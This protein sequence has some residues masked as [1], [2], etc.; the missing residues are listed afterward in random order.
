ML[1]FTHGVLAQN[2]S[3][4]EWVDL[5]LSVNWA[6]CNVGAS[7]PEHFGNYYAWGET[8]PKNTYDWASYKL[9]YSGDSSNNIRFT[10]YNNSEWSG[11]IDNKTVLEPEDD[12][13]NANWGGKWRMPTRSEMEELRTKCRWTFTSINGVNGYR[14]TGPNGNSIFLPASGR[15]DG[16]EL[17]K[18]GTY[19]YYWTSTAVDATSVRDVHFNTEK[20]YEDYNYCDRYKG[21]S[22]RPVY[23]NP[24]APRQ[25]NGNN[26]GSYQGGGVNIPNNTYNNNNYN[27]SQ[28]IYVVCPACNGTGRDQ[29]RIQYNTNG[30]NRY[31]PTCG[32]TGLA[33]EHI[34]GRCGRCDGTGRVK[35]Y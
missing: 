18:S 27:T 17:D 7:K 6:T 3:S 34:Y 13:A 31:C 33:H 15:K 32:T 19:G 1:P 28:P 20:V 23:P 14:V 10:K 26:S 5:G 11:H 16:T 25:N 12:A 22:V 21:L 29:G 9:K 24:N 30:G 2:K 8:K 4:H 35:Q